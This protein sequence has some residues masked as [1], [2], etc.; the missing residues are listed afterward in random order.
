MGRANTLTRSCASPASGTTRP[1]PR[2]R[3]GASCASSTSTCGAPDPDARRV[4]RR[5]RAPATPRHR[6]AAGRR[7]GPAVRRPCRD[8][9]P[10]ALRRNS[11]GGCAP[12]RCGCAPAFGDPWS[13]P[14]TK[15]RRGRGSRRRARS[16]R[17]APR[18]ARR[19]PRRR[20]ARRVRSCHDR[21][22]R[23]DCRCRHAPGSRHGCSQGCGGGHSRPV[24][25]AAPVAP[26]PSARAAVVRAGRRP[27]RG[28]VRPGSARRRAGSRRRPRRGP[29]RRRGLACRGSPLD[30]RPHHGHWSPARGLSSSR[31]R[32]HAVGLLPRGSVASSPPPTATSVPAPPVPG[33][34][35]APG[36]GRRWA[37]YSRGGPRPARPHRPRGG[38]CG[39]LRPAPEH[40]PRFVPHR[41]PPDPRSLAN[42]AAPAGIATAT[43]AVAASPPR[44]TLPAA[45][46]PEHR[47]EPCTLEGEH[48][49]D[50]QQCPHRLAARAGR[51]DTPGSPGS[52]RGGA[53]WRCVA[54]TRLA[55]PRAAGGCRRRAFPARRDRR[56]ARPVPGTRRTSPARG[57]SRGCARSRRG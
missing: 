47:A 4:S 5:A 22:C 17:R 41:A 6:R 33:R 21:S 57:G 56:S 40:P 18:G 42:A 11:F 44:P 43:S 55:T 13:R 30:R 7:P 15:E 36:H 38:R 20:P 51:R 37:A 49:A 10:W 45:S 9:Q 24:L 19:S 39:G 3:G 46:A 28:R 23:R 8:R 54:A 34:S 48:R 29:R 14:V 35:R 53:G 2:T 27:R 25:R 32:L 1:R 31:D 50:R 52:R 16:R 12:D 26:V